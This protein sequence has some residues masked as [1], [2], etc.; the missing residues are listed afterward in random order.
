MKGGSGDPFSALFAGSITAK[1]GGSIKAIID[2][3][4]SSTSFQEGA[5]FL[6]GRKREVECRPFVHFT[7]CPDSPVMAM[8]DALDQGQADPGSFIL[9]IAVQTLKDTEELGVESHI[10]TDAIISDKIDRLTIH[11]S[12]VLQ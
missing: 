2:T 5:S 9:F 3:N 10:K 4:C 12:V 1:I 11:A 6:P 7:L 8:D